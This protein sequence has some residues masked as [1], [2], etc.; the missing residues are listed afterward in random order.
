MPYLI[1][2][3]ACLIVDIAVWLLLNR[4]AGM[5]PERAQIV[6]MAVGGLVALTLFGTRRGTL[7]PDAVGLI[8]SLLWIAV[9][10]IFGSRVI[11]WALVQGYS[12]G[13]FKLALGMAFA[14]ATPAVFRQMQ[15]LGRPVSVA[16]LGIGAAILGALALWPQPSAPKD[17]GEDL[18]A[19]YAQKRTLPD[20][21]LHLF[22]LGH[23]LVGR[24]MPAMLAQMAGA[25]HRY[26]LQLG[27]GTSLREH[28][29][30]DLTINGFD[31]ENDTPRYRDAHEALASGAYDAFVMTE[32]VRLSDAIRYHDSRDYAAK[33][34][35]EA[36]AGNPDIQIFLYESWHALDDGPDWL[37]R[38][39]ADLENQWKSDLLWPATRAIGRPVWLIPAG[40]VMAKLVAEAETSPNGIAE[41]KTHRDLFSDDIH[42]NDLGIYLV[43]LTHYAVI[44][45]R[46]PVGL[47]NQLLRADGTPATPPSPELARRMQEIVW[48]VVRAIP[49]TG[50]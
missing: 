44:Y 7:R 1:T 30:P 24:D 45:G 39:P 17:S 23:S 11:E 5:A 22:Q 4:V 40:Q 33:W 3:A 42:P 35:A 37:T 13:V 16:G 34:A 46:T 10:A 15:A 36:V 31:Q 47:P 48:D 43:A 14:A 2:A 25:G 50:I 19:L 21:P 20:R 32:M 28:Y 38:L 12:G 41:L 26:E 27:W 6:A 49:E 8:L 29:E 9:A 18:R